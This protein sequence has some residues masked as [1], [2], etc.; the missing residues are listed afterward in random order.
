LSIVT[1]DSIAGIMFSL[2][3]WGMHVVFGSFPT[4]SPITSVLSLPGL[5]DASMRPVLIVVA[6]L[7]LL[8]AFWMVGRMERKIGDAA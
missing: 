6:L 8:V 1:S 5:G 7:L 4:T 2:L 3:I